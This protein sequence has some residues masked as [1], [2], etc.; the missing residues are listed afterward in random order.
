MASA[1]AIVHGANNEYRCVV[2]Y[3]C[4]MRRVLLLFGILL[5]AAK[6]QA[7]TD[8]VFWFA[9]P[10]VQQRHADRPIEL[11]LIGLD[12]NSRVT[13]SAP[14][15]PTF[16]PINVNL[17]AGTVA[18]VDL[19]T[20]IN[21]I[22]NASPNAVN[23]N[24]LSIRATT[25][26]QAYYE[27]LGNNLNTDIFTLKGQNALDTAFV[28]P[29]NNLFPCLTTMIGVT[30]YN[31]VLVMASENNT[32]VRITLKVAAGGR[33]AGSTFT[34]TLNK[35]EV[36]FLRSDDGSVAKKLA[37]TII[38]SD[39]KV[40][41]TM[42]DDSVYPGGW[43]SAA[44]SCAD[45]CGDQIVGLN[46]L[47]LNYLAV[48]G[49]A[50]NAP[51][52]D[53]VFISAFT[54]STALKINGIFIKYLAA[55]ET[56]AH[57]MAASE[58]L[59]LVE[60]NQKAAVIQM[61]GFGC[62][63]GMSILPNLEC[64]GSQS[65]AFTR[66][67]ASSGTTFSVTLLVPAG[68]ER[69]F[70]INGVPLSAAR[71]SQF[72]FVPGSSNRWKY[73]KLDLSS[74]FPAISNVLIT[75]DSMI[76]HCG[77]INGKANGS[78]CRFGYFSNFRKVS[79]RLFGPDR[80]D[81]C[82][83][84]ELKLQFNVIGQPGTEWV[85]PNKTVRT[86]S[87]FYQPI[88]RLK[89]SGLYVA[90]YSNPSCDIN[91]RDSVR[92]R[93][94]S[95][96]IRFSA[97]PPRCLGDSLV[98]RPT[99][100]S[101]SGAGPVTWFYGTSNQT[102]PVFRLKPSA[103][104]PLMISA[105]FTTRNGCSIATEDTAL[106]VGYP[107]AAWNEVQGTI[108]AGDSVKLR[109][110]VPAWGT[111]SAGA[112]AQEWRLNGIL[113]SRENMLRFKN[114]SGTAVAVS[115]RVSNA[116]GCADSVQLWRPVESLKV[117][118]IK[119]ADACA[120]EQVSLEASPDWKNSTPA[121]MTW[122]T[123]D[124]TVLAGAAVN[125]HRYNTA[126][127]YGVKFLMQSTAGCK[128][129]SSASINIHESP[130]ATM[131]VS[132]GSCYGDTLNIGFNGNW[133]QTA[134]GGSLVWFANGKK[135]SQQKQFLWKTA[136]ADPLRL[137]V[138]ATNDK[139]CTD[140]AIQVRRVF[141][142]PILTVK[143]PSVCLGDE[144]RLELLPNWGN[145]QA[146]TVRWY[147]HDRDSG[148]GLRFV[149]R[150]PNAGL[151]AV[152]CSAISA[153]GCKAGIE[154]KA[155]VDPGPRASF[156][157]TPA[158]SG[159]DTPFMFSN[160]STGASSWIWNPEPGVFLNSRDL[161]YA[162]PVGGYKKVILVAVSDSGCRDTAEL[163]VFVREWIKFF[164]P[165]AFTPNSDNLNEVFRPFGLEGRVNRYEFRIFNRWGEKLYDGRDATQGW[166]GRF[167]G[168]LCQE[169]QYVYELYYRDYTGRAGYQKGS[170]LL[171]R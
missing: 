26:I 69:N 63:M 93:M 166:D 48:R 91:I 41:V 121:A 74:Q 68:Q 71:I 2:S 34:V 10:D 22:E 168:K 85:L 60:L 141:D 117:V 145:G 131:I 125:T 45:L 80:M 109:V 86:G 3:F 151:Y 56:Y 143:A 89:D 158:V 161:V 51:L 28:V 101:L 35:G 127:V 90:R 108:C 13:I 84:A 130:K 82:S 126:G 37:G 36:Y 95:A 31:G 87:F 159:I 139:S 53:V 113:I 107:K 94:D 140:S 123:G 43:K 154:V 170:F 96:S 49:P 163:P 97:K 33:P 14:A 67:D 65:A 105:G 58:Q 165:N 156:T 64:T 106:V 44:G 75:N 81:L 59:S 57:M 76:F 114:P 77:M 118:G 152:R 19:T 83:G 50:L 29:G 167:G 30:F 23:K 15:N 92:V 40:S 66:S 52:N 134:A 61:S 25:P 169:G 103:V 119:V 120:G 150:Y 38:R 47:G 27:V 148:S 162:Y 112:G 54:D 11:K 21:Q 144:T 133:G 6:G 79:P 110:A 98:I 5:L 17:N 153:E 149:K 160:T 78:G 9:A 46:M 122:F 70:R 147:A 132:G 100:F 55:G 142:L 129:S 16:N 171:L 12:K 42:Y 116:E 4:S 157:Y 146:G 8:T 102:G 32:R 115:L 136:A 155:K 111:Y 39:K 104:G 138:V 1:S 20:W 99:V 62:E 72:A 135:I 164:I 18:R 137:V 24:G 7:Q 73:A 124:G 88:M 128:D